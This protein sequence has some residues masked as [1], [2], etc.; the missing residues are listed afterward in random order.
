MVCD[1]SG[2][3][4]P[5]SKTILSLRDGQQALDDFVL[6]LVDELGDEGDWGE[7]DVF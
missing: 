1:E 2:G 6:K 3:K 7:G 4:P 5:H